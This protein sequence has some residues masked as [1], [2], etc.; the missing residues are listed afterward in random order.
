L[1]CHWLEDEA[2]LF[3]WPWVLLKDSSQHVR[4]VEAGLKTAVRPNLIG[5]RVR[6]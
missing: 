3:V 5:L 6:T 4:A 2:I 1:R